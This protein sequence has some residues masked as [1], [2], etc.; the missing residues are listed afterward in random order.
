MSDSLF[1]KKTV[2]AILKEAEEGLTDAHGHHE[3]LKRVLTVKDLTFFGIAAVIGTGV[4]TAIGAASFHGG[5]AVTL[6][7]AITAVACGFAAYCY[8]EFASTVPVSGSAYT[9]SYV[10]FG[11][12]FAWIIGWDLLMEYA[13]GNIAVAISWSQYFVRVLEGFHIHIPSWLTMDYFTAH[14]GYKEV[15][16]AVAK[17]G[18]SVIATLDQNMTAAYNAWNSAPTL[19]GLRIIMNV[20]ALCIV[21]LITYIVYI[22]IR[23]SKTANNVFVIIKLA[24]ILLVIIAG[25]FYVS[26]V[27]WHPFMPNGFSGVL[28]GVSAVFFA[29]IGFDAISTTAEEC[30]NPQRDLPRAMFNTLIICTVLYIVLVL[31]LTGMTNYTHLNVAD[32][33]AYV[34]KS[35]NSKVTNWLAGIISV[36]AIFVIASVLLVYQLGQP[37][38]W[39]S[40]SRDGLLPKV[41]SRIHPKYRTPSFSTV[42]TGCV[43]GIPALFMNLD[44]V[45]ALTSIG[46]LFAFVLVCGGILVLQKTPNRPPSKFRVPDISGK[47]II[48]AL[49]LLSVILIVIYVPEHFKSLF[50]K[51]GIPMLVFWIVATVVSALSFIKD[52]SLIPV[53]GLLSCFY[54]MAQ[55]SHTNWYRFV[56]WLCIGLVIY[57]FYGRKNSRLAK[58]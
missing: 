54:L 23:E 42:L 6:L 8:A 26:P 34:F 4:F 53:M 39:M 41:F 40:M 19:G 1:R 27:N 51:E 25:A 48:P 33:L 52:F 55:E 36:S 37:R 22:G 2:P 20:P 29:Y 49:F 14:S 38:I 28:S 45:I 43:V 15:A 7:F 50:R 30:K 3:D 5:P 32:P 47:Y 35:Q 46:T 21:A 12:L 11:E 18:N 16:A 56:I 57:F 17:S 9:Y 44:V 31:V 13:I 58:D 10:A 24:V